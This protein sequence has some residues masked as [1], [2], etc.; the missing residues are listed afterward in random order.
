MLAMAR[1]HGSTCPRAISNSRFPLA[2]TSQRTG[3]QVYVVP[4][5]WTFANHSRCVFP[6]LDAAIAAIMAMQQGELAREAAMGG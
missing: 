5:Y 2:P 6:N 1:G 4:Y 3:Q